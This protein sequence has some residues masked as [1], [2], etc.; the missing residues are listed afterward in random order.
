MQ[1]G[2]MGGETAPLKSMGIKQGASLFN[3][4]R[5]GEVSRWIGERGGKKG[6]LVNKVGTLHSQR[7]GPENQVVD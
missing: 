4:G 3:E 2:V 7:K 6:N 5:G 1:G